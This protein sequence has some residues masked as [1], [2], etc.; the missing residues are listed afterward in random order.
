MNK[1]LISVGVRNAIKAIGGLALLMTVSGAEAAVKTLSVSGNKILADGKVESFAGNSLFWSNTGWGGDKYY[2]GSTIGS[3][4]SGW[5]SQIVRAAIGFGEDTGGLLQDWNGNMARLSAVID[6][7]VANDMYVIV[8]LHGHRN[9]QYTNQAKAFFSEISAKY[10]HLPN[11]IYEIYNEPWDDVSWD[12]QIKPYAEQII[13]VIRANDPDN[14]IIVG[15]RAWS[16]R[17]DEAANNPINAKNIAYTLHFYAGTHGQ[18]LRNW[19]DYALGKGI[20]LFVTEWGSVNADGNGGVN[21]GETNNWVSWMK[22]NNISHANWAVNDKNEGASTFNPGGSLTASGS[23]AKDIISAWG[24]SAKSNG[25]TPTDPTNPGNPGK[26]YNTGE[27][28]EAEGYANSFG[29]QLETTSDAGGGQNVGYID[30]GDYMTYNLNVPAAGTYKVSYR[31]A[32]LVGGGTIS[33]EKAGGSPVYGT[34]LV[35]GTGGWQNWVTISHNVTLGAGQQ[36][37]ALAAKA[38]GYNVNWF[39]V[40][41][42]GTNPTDPTNP[43]PVLATIQA[44]DYAAMNGVQ[45]ETTTDAGGGQNVGYIDAGDWLSYT[46]NAVNIPTTGTYTIQFRV[47]SAVGGGVIAFEEAGGN[48]VYGTVSVGNTGGWQNW[49]TVK[50][51]VNLTAGSHKFGINAKSGGFNIN[52]FSITQG[53]Q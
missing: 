30:N 36:T 25:T 26:V 49:T 4:H 9:H 17:V 21:Y 16:Q 51:T 23:F 42:V 24:T 20:A 27:Q 1:N 3:L 7:A 13:P 35:N 43:N 39:R 41:P 40:D 28:I 5:N 50:M 52:W 33:F 45:K 32:S 53:A 38:G 18:Y 37:V 2:N 10:G 46:N 8:D 11:V 29:I 12:S 47:A 22:Q 48:P 19:A 15:T 34:A 14:L 6:A 31:V 44:E